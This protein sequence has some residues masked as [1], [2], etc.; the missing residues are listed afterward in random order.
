MSRCKSRCKSLCEYIID[1][2]HYCDEHGPNENF[3]E[4][5][6][7][8]HTLHD[9]Q[10]ICNNCRENQVKNT[11]LTKNFSS[12]KHR[13]QK[14]MTAS[15]TNSSHNKSSWICSF[16]VTWI[17]FWFCF[18]VWFCTTNIYSF[19]ASSP[20]KHNNS[21]N[22]LS[23]LSIID[24]QI[25]G[26]LSMA[27]T[28]LFRLI[29]GY[30]LPKYGSRFCYIAV[31]LLTAMTLIGLTIINDKI[32]YF[33]CH[34]FLGV[35][36]ASFV[37]TQYHTTQIVSGK[38]YG[39]A[40]AIT[41]GFG[42]FGGGCANSVMPLVLYYFGLS[43]RIYM[44]ILSVFM[45]ILSIIYY[46]MATEDHVPYRQTPSTSYRAIA[47]PGYDAPT[48]QPSNQPTP[49]DLDQ[50]PSLQHGSQSQESNNNPVTPDEN[51][52]VNTYDEHNNSRSLS[53]TQSIQSLQSQEEYPTVGM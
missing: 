26:G 8:R 37:V 52:L 3:R 5:Q 25:A 49:I 13:Q 19:I 22:S 31:L 32:S 30:F 21:T 33:I 34:F 38:V 41:A 29:I 39:F 7:A 45:I 20:S 51:L 27:S 35:T 44:I 2:L 10:K 1:V 12:Q 15:Q 18:F 24:H 14:T 4:I 36:G 46:F 16:H 47:N 40:Q 48:Q 43:W 17:A 50:N 42:N 28:I 11:P 9:T 53:T 23:N 6:S